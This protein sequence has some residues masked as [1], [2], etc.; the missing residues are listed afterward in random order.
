MSRRIAAVLG[1]AIVGL[2]LGAL[3]GDEPYGKA[4]PTTPEAGVSKPKPSMTPGMH[5]GHMGAEKGMKPTGQKDEINA[6]VGK[7]LALVNVYLGQ[8]ILNT[9]ALNSLIDMNVP[10]REPHVKELARNLDVSVKGAITHAGHIR[11]LNDP[12]LTRIIELDRSLKEAKLSLAKLRKAKSADISMHID[13]IGSNL[14]ASEQIFRDM[15]K[16]AN[17]TLL[18]D[19]RLETVPVR[20]TEGIDER[21]KD[22]P[23]GTV[24]PKHDTD[25]LPEPARPTSPPSSTEPTY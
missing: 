4:K 10:V 16:T 25:L 7:H 3:A 8:A 1:A 22:K 24:P 23:P 19:L 5:E 17:F 6:Q 21:P 12:A 11:R 9:K 14:T 2:G 15:A 13:S 20:G 18:D